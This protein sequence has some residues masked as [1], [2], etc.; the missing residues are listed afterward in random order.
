MAAETA[1]LR[2][3][4]DTLHTEKSKLEAD[5]RTH[6]ANL[7]SLKKSF[8][9]TEVARAD[10]EK[11]LASAKEELGAAITSR[12]ELED[13][14]GALHEDVRWAPP[15]TTRRQ[16]SYPRL[17]RQVPTAHLTSPH[18]TSPHLTSPHLTAIP[19]NQPPAIPHNRHTLIT[20]PPSNHHTRPT[21]P[22][23]SS[24][25]R[26]S[27]CRRPSVCMHSYRSRR[28]HR[29]STTL[30]QPWAWAWAW[31]CSPGRP[32]AAP[33]RCHRPTGAAAAA[34]GWAASAASR[35]TLTVATP[36]GRTSPAATRP[37]PRRCS[38]AP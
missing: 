23:C 35:S 9:E 28:W 14:I 20:T 30:A 10:T 38:G 31:V 19:H 33:R 27:S 21:T 34:A 37:W 18:L 6:E 29:P 22:R 16:R 13:E 26:P 3:H 25:T 15:R 5:I 11:A 12:D 24:S 32:A 36:R 7:G 17:P 8:N 2:S 4:L 1:Q